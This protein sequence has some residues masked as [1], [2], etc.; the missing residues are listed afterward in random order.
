MDPDSVDAAS[1]TIDYCYRVS[2]IPKT[3]DE[4]IAS[5]EAHKWQKA[6]KDEMSSLED[7]NTYELVPVPQD[8]TVV[9][10]RWVYAVKL[11]PEGFVKTNIYL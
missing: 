6:M 7:N 10:G 11:G 9:G 1:C 8:R 2:D 4:A 5:P 3:Y